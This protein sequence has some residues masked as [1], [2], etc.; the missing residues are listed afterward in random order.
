MK[1]ILIVDNEEKFCKVIQSALEFEKI[2]SIY[3]LS[4]ETALDWLIENKTDI[5]LTDLRMDGIDGLELL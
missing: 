2:P 1:P 3:T 4:G 5:L